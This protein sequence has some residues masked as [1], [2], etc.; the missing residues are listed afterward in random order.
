M[1]IQ[2]FKLE[3][4]FA[5]YEFSVPYLLCSS[6]CEALTLAEL[7]AMADQ[8]SLK[9]WSELKL[10]YTEPLGHPLLRKEASMQYERVDPEEILVLTPEEGIYIAMSALLEKGDHLIVTYPGYQSLYEIARSKG[11]EISK[12]EPDKTRGWRFDVDDLAGAIASHTKMIVINFPH[13]PTGATIKKEDLEKI[14]DIARQNGIMIFSD[15]MYRF[16]EYDESARLPAVADI[17]ENGVSLSGMSK[18]YALAGLRI[19]WLA[20]KNAALFDSF[21][22]YKDYTTICSGAPSEI[23][24]ICALRKKEAIL[25]RNARIIQKNIALLDDFFAQ[26]HQTLE[27]NRPVAGTMGFPRLKG[28]INVEDFC[29]ALADQKGVMLL[30]SSQYDYAGN[31]FRIGFARKGMPEALEKLK[32]Y[33]HETGMA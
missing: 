20:T 22:T 24:A 15:E 14:V 21:A 3:R 33:M 10:G 26:F 5:K 32:E 6:D 17:Y 28:N 2:P 23:L 13:N 7:L 1:T 29:L 4:Y 9:L 11:C 18:S 30:P 27:W 12:W 8:E 19:G 25:K 16:L 31:H